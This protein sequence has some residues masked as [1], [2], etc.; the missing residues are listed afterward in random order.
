[1]LKEKYSDNQIALIASV[2]ESLPFKEG[3]YD[4]VFSVMSL[5]HIEKIEAA[6]NEM[7]R[8]LNNNGKLVVIDW[9]QEASNL[10]N[11]PPSHFLPFNIFEGLLSKLYL[12]Y[13]VKE[14]S[15]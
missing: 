15:T 7:V 4:I 3:F 12:N 11:Q 2:S 9:T 8:V 6:L 1:M 14:Y 10:M 5:H 13:Q